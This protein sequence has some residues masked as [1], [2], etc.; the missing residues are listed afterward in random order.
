MKRNWRVPFGFVLAPVLPCTLA[1]LIPAAIAGRVLEAPSIVIPTILVSLALIL[2]VYVPAYFLLKRFWRV[3][4][5]E[6]LLMGG[7]TALILNI[8]LLAVSAILFSGGGDSAGDSGGPTIVDGRLTP[9][10]WWGAVHGLTYHVLLGVS[11]GLC[12]WFIAIRQRPTWR[13]RRTCR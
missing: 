13:S 11:I 6:C 9:H 1:G 8:G 10:G 2:V 5:L 4:L 7:A 3:R 12:F